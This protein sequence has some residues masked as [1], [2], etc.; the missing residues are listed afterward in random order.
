MCMLID[1]TAVGHS[2]TLSKRARAHPELLSLLYRQPCRVGQRTDWTI[3]PVAGDYFTSDFRYACAVTPRSFVQTNTH[4]QART[5]NQNTT[6]RTH[7]QTVSGGASGGTARLWR[8][9]HTHTQDARAILL[10]GV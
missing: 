4:T 8:G 7:G 10:L 9:A 6:H 5:T 2:V 3:S 1:R